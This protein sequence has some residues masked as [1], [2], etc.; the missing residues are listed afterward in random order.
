MIP[1]LATTLALAGESPLHSGV[2]TPWTIGAGNG[3]FG[4]FRPLSVGLGDKTEVGSNGLGTFLA[5]EVYAKRTVW[6]NESCAL[7]VTGSVGYPGFGLGMLQTGFLQLIA[8]DQ[9]IPATGVV[10]VG[11]LA[12][13][14]NDHWVVSA[15]VRT[16]F[17]IPFE[18]GT[19]RFQDHAWFDP[20]I[21]PVA[22]GWSVQPGVRVDWLPTEGW[23]LSGDGRVELS[24]GPDFGGKLFALRA[25]GSH[26]AVGAGIAGAYE[27]YGYGYPDWDPE[28]RAPA[29]AI[30]KDVTPLLDVQ[31]RW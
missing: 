14:R 30:F 12:G 6:E 17:G 20:Y 5:P 1:L 8:G 9:E 23:V 3:A 29:P 25:L 4:L 16:R 15:R 21:A 10:G 22:S 11:A 19:M 13:W 7:A 31:G 26:V 27:K 24:G 28:T 18:E 2:Q